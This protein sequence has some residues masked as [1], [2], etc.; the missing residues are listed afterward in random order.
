MRW[1]RFFGLL[2]IDPSVLQALARA[3]KQAYRFHRAFQSGDARNW[4]GNG[5][6][7]LRLVERLLAHQNSHLCHHQLF[8]LSS[9]AAQNTA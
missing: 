7:D 4:K 2:I 9:S 5:G 6:A 3:F 1:L 8:R